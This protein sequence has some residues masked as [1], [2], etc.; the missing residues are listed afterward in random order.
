[1]KNF[2][3]ENKVW[4][5]IC[6]ALILLLLALGLI[7]G[8]MVS[9]RKVLD[10]NLKAATEEMNQ[11]K[12]KNGDL[13][14][15][16]QS[17]VGTIE[18]L[19]GIIATNKGEI[20]DLQKRLDAK[21]LYISSLEAELQVK[22]SEVHDTTVVYKDSTF[23]FAFQFKDQWYN[24]AG[25]SDVNP[26]GAKTWMD[27]ISME[28]PLKVGLTENWEIFATTPNPYVTFSSIEG[29]VL[30]K[31]AYLQQKK[32]RRWGLTV[33]AG[34]NAGYDIIGKGFYVGPGVGIGIGYVIF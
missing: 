34:M 30:D 29:A 3:K 22:P 1:M 11:L 5:A 16:R 6:G 25:H 23:M 19:E 12:T 27:N 33:Y 13:L 10:A 28:I 9:N 21:V 15:E 20:K 14:V 17:Y 31:S 32:V 18:E 26:L 8:K 24:V 4:L 2:I 7:C